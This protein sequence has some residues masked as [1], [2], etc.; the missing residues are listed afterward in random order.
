MENPIDF[1]KRPVAV[2]GMGLS[3]EAACRLLRLYGLK[4]NDLLTFDDK[5]GAA[6]F[7]DPEK[8]LKKQPQTLVVSPGVPLSKEWIQEFLEQGGAVTSELALALHFLEREKLIGVTG[9][10]GKSTVVSLL[11]AGLKKFSSESFVG[12]NIGRPFADYISDIKEKKRA[13]APWVVLELSSYQLENM[14][15]LHCE[16]SAITY[17]TGNHLDR[18]PSLEAY[19]NQKWEL[20]KRTNKAVVL[21]SHGGDLKKYAR[22]R[23]ESAELLWTDQNDE[24]LA[25][26]ELNEAK[27]LGAHNQDNLAVAAKL[28]REA[29]WPEE[30]ILGMKEFPGLPHRMENLGIR[31]K[32]RFVNDSKATT[33]ESVK[34]AALGIYEQMDRKTQLV[35]LLGGRDKNLP[36]A[37]LAELK[38]IQK[39]RVLFFGECAAKAKSLSGLDGEEFPK[40]KDAVAALHSVAKS[41]DIVLLSPGGTSRDEF[42]SFEDRGKFF[43]EAVRK[44]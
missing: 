30:A 34:T 12:G 25:K 18:Y 9:S 31:Q 44:A 17:L 37:D 28:A 26:Y 42:K 21:N 5:L 15:N 32:I 39:L 19:Y 7:S 8:L 11:E 14:G 27:L 33:I 6:D 16:L 20:V 29:G 1:L 10:V 24:E 35:L 23:K 4:K 40:L 41:G 3:G 22:G 13:R 36:W 38:R 43:A 2:V